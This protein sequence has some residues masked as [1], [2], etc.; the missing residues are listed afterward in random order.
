[1]KCVSG[2]GV[3]QCVGRLGYGLGSPGLSIT[4]IHPTMPWVPVFVPGV[5]RPGLEVNH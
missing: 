2:H 1:M 4:F 5:K 3:A